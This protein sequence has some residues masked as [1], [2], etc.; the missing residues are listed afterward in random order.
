[1]AV[2]MKELRE[3]L[4]E[5]NQKQPYTSTNDGAG[6]PFWDI[7]AGEQAVVRFLPDADQDNGY[8]WKERIM[9]NLEFD[10][11]VG[12]STNGP[13]KIQV[14]SME[15]W[16]EDCPILKEARR[17][18]KEGRDEL[19][20]KYWKKK[21][22][23]FQGLIRSNP[24]TEENLP[25]NP[26]RRLTMNASLYKIVYA[27]LMDEDTEYSPTDHEHGCDFRI[28]KTQNGTYADYGTSDFAR[29]TSALTDSELQ[30]IEQYGL[31]NLADFLPK[32]PD[33]DHLNAIQ[34]MF[35]ASLNGDAYDPARFANFYRPYGLEYDATKKVETKVETA[36]VEAKDDLPWDEE[37]ESTPEP[38]RAKVS[39]QE[40]L[41]KLKKNKS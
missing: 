31:F 2:N 12:Q 6:F 3:R 30:E 23:L 22:F 16:K 21:S 13:I 34:E 41:A 18:Y 37:E 17:F 11:I 33:T 8:F 9:I 32:K 28:K 27:Y 39:P 36:K 38:V 35:E 1:M 19:G 40:L 24:L 14:P 15:M 7:K 20:Q 26:I 10:G 29:K 25:E 4:K 5:E